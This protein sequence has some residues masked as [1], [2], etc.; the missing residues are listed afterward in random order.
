MHVVSDSEETCIDAKEIPYYQS[1][2]L[3]VSYTGYVPIQKFG[4]HVFKNPDTT[5]S[6]CFFSAIL[7]FSRKCESALYYIVH[8]LTVV[9]YTIFRNLVSSNARFIEGD[10]N[11]ELGFQNSR[12]PKTTFCHV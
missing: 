2:R 1:G 11:H 6:R 9:L 5:S 10:A 4:T 7:I 12:T 8:S 3:T